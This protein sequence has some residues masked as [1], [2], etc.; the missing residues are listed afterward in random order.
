MLVL[1]GFLKGMCLKSTVLIL[2]EH[3]ILPSNDYSNNE[4][5]ELLDLNSQEPLKFL[6]QIL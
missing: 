3:K 6:F 4:I 1:L 2:R 5:E